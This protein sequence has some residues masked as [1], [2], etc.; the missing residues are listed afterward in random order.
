VLDF[1]GDPSG[2]RTRV[3]DVRGRCPN[4]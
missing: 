2:S 1:V 3:T 4:H